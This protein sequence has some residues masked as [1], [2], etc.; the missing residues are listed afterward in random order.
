MSEVSGSP[1]G[2]DIALFGLLSPPAGP[3]TVTVVF[4]AASQFS[5]HAISWLGVSAFGTAETSTTG[6]G[7]STTASIVIAAAVGDA[8][9]DAIDVQTDSSTVTTN[10]TERANNFHGQGANTGR[11]VTST[12]VGAAS[13]T[14]TYTYDIARISS[15]I[16][17][18]LIGGVPNQVLMVMSE[19]A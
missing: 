8:V 10:Q 6:V 4:T 3:Q 17:M 18:S 15:M 5:A 19:G 13:V 2:T 1:A 16:A 7:T 12:A 11:A 14:M 9:M